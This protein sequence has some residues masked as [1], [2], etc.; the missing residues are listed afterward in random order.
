M[1]RRFTVQ[2]QR[3]IR[4]G[5]TLY[6]T[7]R[8]GLDHPSVLPNHRFLIDPSSLHPPF[9]S[10]FLP[11]LPRV[12]CQFFTS[13][14]LVR[15]FCRSFPPS[16][17]PPSHPYHFTNHTSCLPSIHPSSSVHL[18]RFTDRTVR[19]TSIHPYPSVHSSPPFR[20]HF[21]DPTFP[22]FLLFQHRSLRPSSLI[23]LSFLPSTRHCF[24]LFLSCSLIIYQ[25]I[26]SSLFY[27]S[28]HPVAIH[29]RTW[30]AAAA[31]TA[32]SSAPR[33]SLLP[34]RFRAFRRGHPTES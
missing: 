20:R 5:T 23:L 21:T 10:F 8:P 2:V 9:P 6:R 14:D 3:G 30:Q 25:I 4:I 15:P 29:R 32:G 1:G 34:T 26:L 27:N 11:I 33:N 22:P 12:P 19:P 13:S 28:A 7:G 17:F 18:Y 31:S 16:I 24:I